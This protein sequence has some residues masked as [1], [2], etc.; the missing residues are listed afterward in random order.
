MLYIFETKTSEIKPLALTLTSVYGI[1]VNQAKLICKKLGFSSTLR[2]NQLTDN[3]INDLIRFISNSDF[4]IN[5]E[6]KK[7]ESLVIKNL[8]AIKSRRGLRRLSGLPVR[9]QRT[10]TNSRSARKFIR[11]Y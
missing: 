8:I 7:V 11:I 1:G 5:N 2:P 10:K 4:K 9:G 6:L 3:Q